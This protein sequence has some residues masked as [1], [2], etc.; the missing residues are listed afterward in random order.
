MRLPADRDDSFGGFPG[1]MMMP[2]GLG[3]RVM[4]FTG[5]AV[6]VLREPLLV[7]HA[8]SPS[9]HASFPS[10]LGT[11]CLYRYRLLKVE[12]RQDFVVEADLTK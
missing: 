11:K 9:T 4:D 8:S 1:W 12:V 5:R 6:C 7:S 2:Q 10:C 3:N